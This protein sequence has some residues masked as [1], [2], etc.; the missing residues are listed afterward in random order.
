MGDTSNKSLSSTFPT[1]MYE[2]IISA[3]VKHTVE[4]TEPA[5]F[6][7][8]PYSVDEIKKCVSKYGLVCAYV[9]IHA[10]DIETHR[11][12]LKKLFSSRVLGQHRYSSLHFEFVWCDH[13][14][15]IA[16]VSALPR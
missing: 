5:N 6:I 15:I 3:I 12:D 9:R 16:Y 14:D 13:S 11:G 2:S 8:S 4:G 1:D 7:D 10:K